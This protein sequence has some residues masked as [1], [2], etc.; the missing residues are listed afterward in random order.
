MNIH[1]PAKTKIGFSACP[2]DC[3]STCALEVELLDERTI[4]R[5]RGAKS[6]S[7]TQGVI[8]E[9]VARYAERI[10]HPDRLLYPLK[11]I[12]KK[13]E[14][15]FERVSWDTA[16]DKIG[17]RFNAI[18]AEYGAEAIWPY[19]YAGTMGL[20][21]R[22][23]IERLRHV[24]GYSGMY[25]TFCVSLGFAGYFAGHGR[26]TGVD[27]R[28]M[29]KSDL[30]VV[31][32]G[33]PVNTQVNV[34]HHIG[35]ARK[36][37]NAEMA[38]VDIYDTGTMKQADHKFIIKPGTDGALACALMHV[39]FRDGLADSSYL[40]QYTD[41]PKG[42]EAHL[43]DKTPE[44]AAEITGLDVERIVGFAHLLGRTKRTF[45]RIGYG[46]T[47]TRNGAFNMHAVTCLPVVAGHWPHE[48]GGALFSG[49]GAYG[50]DKTLIMGKDAIK[51]GRVMDQSR[52]GDVL[53]SNPKDLQ[54]GPPVKA[55]FIQNTN[56]ASVAPNQSKVR[57]GF[58]REDLFTVVHEQFMTDTARYA[59][60][61]LPA[62][63][64][65]E[66]DDVYQAS[67]HQS[68]LF[69]RKL[70]EAPGECR[71][72]HEVLSEIARRVGAEHRGFE[73]TPR[74]IID[75]TLTSSKRRGLDE[76]D[77]ENWF[78]TQP[79][80]ET[81]HFVRGFGHPDGKFRFKPDWKK[82]GQFMS[83]MGALGEVESMPGFPDFWDVREAVD[84]ETPF[85]LATSPSRTYL[86][87]SFTE[88]PGSQ[89]R[90]GRPTLLIHPLDLEAA[91]LADGDKVRI[92]NARGEV[93]LHVKAHDGQQRGTLIA[94]GIWPNSA[95]ENGAGI[96]TLVGSDQPAPAGG[97]AF[98]D[99]AVWLKSASI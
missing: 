52:I 38:C 5:V 1:A 35:L 25:G 46:F 87:S 6:H 10:H 54:G 28:E 23:G 84:A 92:G 47:R 93:F 98:H 66:H 32:G 39:M 11:R 77:Q 53:L 83:P 7:Y 16:L 24:K 36:A 27:S 18:E 95:Y 86:N 69:G 73:M 17:L 59:D 90:E 31:W 43:K 67:G 71:S 51:R 88:T 85:R 2:H 65:L 56:P 94:E 41:D 68:I 99:S 78:Y 72:N 14:G 70:V 20:V 33:N 58:E 74:Q 30:I 8:C 75:E 63:M 82:A 49:S 21:M 13:G 89:K 40:D 26:V 62:T 60:I 9:K 81:S 22:D 50:W 12:G 19:W 29:Q 80:F 96:N 42:F 57:A 3:P 15:K 44:W 91:R 34:M 61:V 64:F 79:D 97:G 45:F 76:L 48:G 37:R 4:G 55:L